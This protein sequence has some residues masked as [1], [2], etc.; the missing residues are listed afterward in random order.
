M[1]TWTIIDTGHRPGEKIVAQ[2]NTGGLILKVA[3]AFISPQN[4]YIYKLYPVGYKGLPTIEKTD[5]VSIYDV[6]YKKQ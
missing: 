2:H 4:P 3:S 5:T 1:N 6:K